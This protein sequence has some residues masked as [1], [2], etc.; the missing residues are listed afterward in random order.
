MDAN[1]IAQLIGSVGFPIV[2]AC[3]MF[4]LYHTTIT[5]LNSILIKIDTTMEMV[6]SELQNLSRTGTIE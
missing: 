2:A 3:G 4:Y 5:N 1:T 6:L